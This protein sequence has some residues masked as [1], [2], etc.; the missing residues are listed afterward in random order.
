[1]KREDLEWKLWGKIPDDDW[2]IIEKVSNNYPGFHPSIRLGL[3]ESMYVSLG[4]NVFKDMLHRLEA[5]CT[6]LE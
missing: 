4:I 1:M 5:E 3:I 6:K 2:E